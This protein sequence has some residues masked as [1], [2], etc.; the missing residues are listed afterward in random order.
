[1]QVATTGRLGPYITCPTS[2]ELSV[3]PQ[4]SIQRFL[5]TGKKQLIGGSCPMCKLQLNE[6]REMKEHV[7]QCRRTH[8]HPLLMRTSYC[9]YCLKR[10]A[11]AYSLSA[12]I[13]RCHSSTLHDLK[14]EVL[15]HGPGVEVT[16]FPV[17][18]MSEP[19]PF[20]C[21]ACGIGWPSAIGIAGH[22]VE[23]EKMGSNVCGGYVVVNISHHAVVSD[24]S[25]NRFTINRY[26]FASPTSCPYCTRVFDEAYQLSRHIKAVHE[27]NLQEPECKQEPSSST[28]NKTEPFCCTRCCSSFKSMEAWAEH[29][30]RNIMECRPCYGD[31]HI[32]QNEGTVKATLENSKTNTTQP[33]TIKEEPPEDPPSA[34]GHATVAAA[35]GTAA[36]A[37]S[38]AASNGKAVVKEEPLEDWPSTSALGNGATATAIVKEEPLDEPSCSFTTKGASICEPPLKRIRILDKS[39]G[40]HRHPAYVQRSNTP[41]IFRCP[42]C[43]ET[44]STHSQYTVH[45]AECVIILASVSMLLLHETHICEPIKL[46][47]ERERAFG[48]AQACCYCD[49]MRANAYVLGNHMM[50][51]RCSSCNV[52][53]EDPRVLQNHFRLRE[54][55]GVPCKGNL[56]ED[57]KQGAKVPETLPDDN[58]PSSDLW[59]PRDPAPRST[60]D[61]DTQKTQC[62]ECAEVWP[63]AQIKLHVKMEHPRYYYESAPF[64]CKKCKK[65][66]FTCP[67]RY[68]EHYTKPCRSEML[69]G[70]A[71]VRELACASRYDVVISKAL[72]KP[73]TQIWGLP[74]I[75]ENMGNEMRRCSYCSLTC[76]HEKMLQHL[77][78]EHPRQHFA[79]APY[80][81]HK[82]GDVG[83]YKFSLFKQHNKCNGTI[84]PSLQNSI[85]AIT[86]KDVESA[87]VKRKDIP[88]YRSLIDPERRKYGTFTAFNRPLK[89]PHCDQVS[90]PFLCGGCGQ[91]FNDVTRLR[92]H[93][94]NQNLLGTTQCF[95]MAIVHDVRMTAKKSAPL[96]PPAHVNTMV[97]ARANYI[98]TEYPVASNWRTGTTTGTYRS[99]NAYLRQAEAKRTNLLLPIRPL[100]QMTKSPLLGERFVCTREMLTAQARAKQIN[101]MIV[102]QHKSQSLRE[103]R[104]LLSAAYTSRIQA[105]VRTTPSVSRTPLA[106]PSLA[107][108]QNPGSGPGSIVIRRPV[109]STA[110]ARPIARIIVPA[111]PSARAKYSIPAP[112]GQLGRN[113]INKGSAGTGIS[114]VELAPRIRYV[115]QSSR[116]Q[117]SKEPKQESATKLAANHGTNDDA[118]HEPF[119]IG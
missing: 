31:V 3:Q 87:G 53:F 115:I 98:K 67:W 81:C 46:S 88:S 43:P 7:K 54:E 50:P 117:P 97:P 96:D 35:T 24:E 48:Q 110:P 58:D 20:T 109:Q 84:P 73:S 111:Q 38:Q 36:A 18:A 28:M 86:M 71:D 89:C 26:D 75:P 82:C 16:G 95:D 30:H 101:H 37:D 68:A 107:T 112:P 85:Y 64:K 94:F 23:M 92:K 17:C 42:L 91:I 106:T 77:K 105:P 27:A 40:S 113:T 61:D 29:Y 57:M 5:C 13:Q 78:K 56:W 119:R 32:I 103:D 74:G 55:F 21:S 51:F 39:A 114:S 76:S 2:S 22:Y 63:R 47:Q 60:E 100:S 12:H 72:A 25:R 9:P 62:P 14:T 44:F 33:A 99:D 34:N 83:F 45:L 15:K 79:D 116:Q 19:F 104:A 41:Q 59:C 49:K 108:R 4:A 69:P 66:A 90:D 80:Q 1:M 52:G 70:P 65:H 11:D 102:Q 118:W 8:Q 93:L 10:L 6:W